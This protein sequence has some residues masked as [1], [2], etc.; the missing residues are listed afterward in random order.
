MT[1]PQSAK[2]SI[3]ALLGIV[4]MTIVL[5][6][7]IAS[8]MLIIEQGE[9]TVNSTYPEGAFVIP[10]ATGTCYQA[11]GFRAMGVSLYYSIISFGTVGYG[12]SRYVNIFIELNLFCSFFYLCHYLGI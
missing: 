6:I 1:I 5:V 7:I 12:K 8:L 11:S 4:F 9:F 2:E 3:T 10:D